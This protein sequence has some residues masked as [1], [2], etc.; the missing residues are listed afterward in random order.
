MG[1]SCNY[2]RGYYRYRGRLLSRG[3]RDHK[4]RAARGDEG[5]ANRERA[6]GFLA[7]LRRYYSSGRACKQALG[8]D[9][10]LARS[11]MLARVRDC[12]R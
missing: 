8:A 6:L 7:E 12:V 4:R 2:S 10:K 9:K 11:A 1:T 3:E 5:L